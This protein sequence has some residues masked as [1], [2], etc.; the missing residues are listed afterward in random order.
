MTCQRLKKENQARSFLANDK[1][2][3]HIYSTK[4]SIALV[5]QASFQPQKSS[6]TLTLIRVANAYESLAQLLAYYDE[7]NNHKSGIEEPSL[8]CI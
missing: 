1:Y 7:F 5:N 4:A 3:E 2:E 6:S 8:Y